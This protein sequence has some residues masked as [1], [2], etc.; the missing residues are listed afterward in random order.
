MLL[1]EQGIGGGVLGWD[2]CAL[3]VGEHRSAHLKQVQGL[4][5]VQAA[6]VRATCVPLEQKKVER[7]KN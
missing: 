1:W 2:R 7:K 5:L 4:F 6:L 3:L